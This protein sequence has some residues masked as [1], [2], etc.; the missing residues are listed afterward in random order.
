[1]GARK[2]PIFS[3]RLRYRFESRSNRY[4]QEGCWDQGSV[5]TWADVQ[6]REGSRNS[7]LKSSARPFLSAASK[8]SMVSLW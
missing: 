3:S 2:I 5:L 7:F 1:M 4:P 6:A 8:A